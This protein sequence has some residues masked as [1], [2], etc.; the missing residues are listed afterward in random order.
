[1]NTLDLKIPPPLVALLT[2]VCMWLL[3]HFAPIASFILPARGIIAVTV[4]FLAV[5]TAVAA[6]VSFRRAR[7]TVNP[8]QP[9]KASSL[10]TSGIFSLTRNPMYLGLLLALLAWS[11]YLSN[12]LPFLLLPAFILYINRFQ[13]RPE[14]TALTSLFG[15]DFTAYQSRVRRWL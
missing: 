14:E 2:A 1:M 4:A 12:A 15:P 10:V 9:N 6:V 7:T 5:L 13:I 8:F 11:I 3:A